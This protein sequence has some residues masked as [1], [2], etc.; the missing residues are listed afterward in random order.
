VTRARAGLPASVATLGLMSA[1]FFGAEAY[2]PLSLTAV[3]GQSMLTAGVALT[4]ATLCWTAGT[5]IQERLV[6]RISY[7]VL[8]CVGLLLIIAGVAGT[9]SVLAASVPVEVAPAMWGIAGLGMG[10]AYPTATLVGL[11]HA[12]P[13]REGESAAALQLANVLG[14][15][16][17]TGVGGGLLALAT[18]AGHSTALGIGA[19]D[20]FALG[21]GLLGLAAAGRL[22]REPGVERSAAPG[23][24]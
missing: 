4:A 20:L 17:G 23:I 11:E 21:V 9:G 12:P 3:R 14:T 5:W 16:L 13:G 1:A 22:R 18:A 15:A 6:H 7:R 8:G 10:I 24:A 19:A 2:V